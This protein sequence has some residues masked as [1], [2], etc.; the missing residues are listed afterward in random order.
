VSSHRPSREKWRFFREPPPPKEYVK[1]KSPPTRQG[2]F[3]FRSYRPAKCN[4]PSY[5]G[6]HGLGKRE[7]SDFVGGADLDAV[8]SLLYRTPL[9][10]MSEI[11]QERS[12]FCKHSISHNKNRH[13]NSKDKSFGR[14]DK[15]E[16]RHTRS[17]ISEFTTSRSYPHLKRVQRSFP[18]GQ[19]EYLLRATFENQGNPSTLHP[20]GLLR[21]SPCRAFV[22]APSFLSM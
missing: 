22:A 16:D 15:S 3:G 20:Q 9:A 10:H 1:R 12:T 18:P 14:F 5:H 21:P 2:V 7:L 13:P 4:R 11:H 17:R 6:R 19:Q 8:A